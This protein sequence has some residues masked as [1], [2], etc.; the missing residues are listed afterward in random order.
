LEIFGGAGFPNGAESTR[1]MKDFSPSIFT[2]EIDRVP[3]KHA[4][5]EAILADETVREQL[6]RMTSGGKPLCDDYSI[7][8][9]RIAR[10][11]ERALFFENAASILTAAGGLAVLL[12]ALDEAS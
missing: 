9:M 1:K 6:R 11:S 10:A 5:V 3:R 2:I 8:R 7:F 12:L 4:E